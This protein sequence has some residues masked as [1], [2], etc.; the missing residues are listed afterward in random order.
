MSKPNASRVAC[1]DTVQSNTPRPVGRTFPKR[2][3]DTN[4]RRRERIRSVSPVSRA[5]AEPEPVSNN[6]WRVLRPSTAVFILFSEIIDRAICFWPSRVP[7]DNSATGP[8]QIVCPGFG[9]TAAD[10]GPRDIDARGDAR[11]REVSRVT[12]LFSETS[13]AYFLRR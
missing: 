13:N 8:A 9:V 3:R 12:S 4:G 6:E 2:E 10:S 1:A 11:P 7:R 5:I